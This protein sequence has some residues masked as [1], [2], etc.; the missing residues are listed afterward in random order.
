MICLSKIGKLVI[1]LFVGRYTNNK[2]SLFIAELISLNYNNRI[3]TLK[4]HGKR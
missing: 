1:F 3:E 2:Y 4:K